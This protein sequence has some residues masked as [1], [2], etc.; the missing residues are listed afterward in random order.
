[1]KKLFFLLILSLLCFDITAQVSPLRVRGVNLVD[2]NGKVVR[3]RGVSFSWHNWWGQYYT[4][5]MVSEMKNSWHCNIVRASIGVGPSN[6]YVKNSDYAQKCLD[7]VVSEAVKQNLY[8]IIDFHSHD[9]EKKTAISFFKIQ[10]KKY[11]HYPNVIFELFNEPVNQPWDEL[12]K[13]AVE[14]S[15]VI[16]KYSDNL[17]LMGTPQWCQQI[18]LA[19]TS[20]IEDV[21]NLMYTLHFY[22]NTHKEPLRVSMEKAVKAG[23]PVFVSECGSMSADGNGKINEEEFFKWTNLMEK[24]SI[25]MIFWSIAD[26]DEVCSVIKPNTNPDT[27]LKDS[28]ITDWGK[29]CKDYITEHNK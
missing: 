15:K 19:V 29:I 5:N 21:D 4:A 17:I 28:D 2:E 18:N 6:D 14:V 9:L 12:K 20:P 8:V 27:P 16:R 23:V 13:Y 24:Y 10:A 22:A 25:P 11:G 7:A 26:K 1:M 3:L